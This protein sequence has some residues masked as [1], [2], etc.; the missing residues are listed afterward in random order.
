MAEELILIGCGVMAEPYL[1][2]AGRLGVRVAVVETPD[3]LIHL[4]EEWPLADAEPLTMDGTQD[5]SWVGPAQRLAERVA[6]RAENWGC[7]AFS[8]PHVLAAALVQDAHGLPGPGLRAALVSRNKALQRALLDGLVGQPL[9][10]LCAT[11]RDGEEWLR[12]HGAGVVKPLDGMG[13]SG[14]ERVSGP[15]DIDDMLR[16]RGDDGPVL[17]EAYVAAQEYSLEAFVVDGEL[18]L[19]TLTHKTTADQTNFVEVAHRVAYEQEEPAVAASARATLETVVARLGVQTGI[20]CME[21]RYEHDRPVVMETMVR[22][23]GDHILETVSRAHRYDVFAAHINAALGR[24]D[25]AVSDFRGRR[26]RGPEP[27]AARYAACFLVAP[28]EGELQQIDLADLEEAGHVVRWGARFQRGDRVRPALSSADRVAYAILRAPDAP[29]LSRVLES[30]LAAQRVHIHPP[31][32]KEP[33][34][35]PTA[36]LDR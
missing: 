5:V 10:K 24:P 6:R 26:D 2:A 9:F 28:G 21:F 33:P 16:R 1:A 17:C 7:I 34:H 4:R 23:P 15:E 11:V 32:R 30:A 12:R 25:A 27:D 13:S 36:E 14:V 19:A 22:M 18:R 35:D 20:V 3:R 29:A 31:A 8:E